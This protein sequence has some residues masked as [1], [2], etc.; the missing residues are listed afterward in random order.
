M[1]LVPPFPQHLVVL[2]ILAGHLLIA[3]DHIKHGRPPPMNGTR[4][5]GEK[6]SDNTTTG[7]NAIWF[8]YALFYRVN[9]ALM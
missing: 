7:I 4:A 5:G 2:S 8:M 9:E 3:V 6:H 1:R